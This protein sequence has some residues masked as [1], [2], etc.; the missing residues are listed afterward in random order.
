MITVIPS[1]TLQDR[2][3]ESLSIWAEAKAQGSQAWRSTEK[4]LIAQDSPGRGWLGWI[5]PTY[6]LEVHA[7]P[8]VSS[9]ECA[10]AGSASKAEK[11]VRGMRQVGKQPQG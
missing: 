10:E 4:V 7:R 9:K 2:F 5:C 8:V 11:A 1:A 6:E 3:G